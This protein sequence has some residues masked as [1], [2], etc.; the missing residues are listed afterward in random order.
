[1]TPIQAEDI[2]LGF[3]PDPGSR[4][5]RVVPFFPPPNLTGTKKEGEVSRLEKS[6]G[7][8]NSFDDGHDGHARLRSA[9]FAHG[10]DLGRLARGAD[11]SGH[12]A[13]FFHVQHLLKVL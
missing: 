6:V 11:G 10:R 13:Y 7:R 4:R 2:P 9:A 3:L 5:E 1:M 12:R 8:K